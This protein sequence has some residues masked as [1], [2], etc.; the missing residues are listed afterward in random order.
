MG[1]QGV[2]QKSPRHLRSGQPE[3]AQHGPEPAEL[4]GSSCL[5]PVIRGGSLIICL[6]AFTAA[7][8]LLGPLEA[9]AGR[10]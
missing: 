2:E 3:P 8:L 6:A 5:S 1:S 9:S 4:V 7:T 10:T